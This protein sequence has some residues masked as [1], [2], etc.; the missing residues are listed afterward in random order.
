M[1]N[2]DSDRPLWDDSPPPSPT[3]DPTPANRHSWPQTK[4][5]SV[6]EDL[7]VKRDR[8]R[9]RNVPASLREKR[10]WAGLYYEAAFPSIAESSRRKAKARGFGILIN[11]SQWDFDRSM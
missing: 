3:L 8:W 4:K 6:V 10:S 5:L 9:A 7:L 1:V 11:A 2:P